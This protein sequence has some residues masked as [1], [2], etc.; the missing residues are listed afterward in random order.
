MLE[1]GAELG[2]DVPFFVQGR[3]A[4]GRGRGEIL[5]ETDGLTAGWIVI[6]KPEVNRGIGKVPGS[7]TDNVE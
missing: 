2:S 1:M 4:I 6:V 3:P 7:G 5:E